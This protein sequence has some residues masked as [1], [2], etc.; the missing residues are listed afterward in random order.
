MIIG[1]LFLVWI[2]QPKVSRSADVL[3]NIIQNSNEF[4]Q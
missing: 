2:L 1:E 4:Y 3:F